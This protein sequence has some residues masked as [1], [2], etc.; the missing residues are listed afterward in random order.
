MTPLN[1]APDDARRLRQAAMDWFVRRRDAGWCAPDE[2]AFQA[3]LAADPR[4]AEVYAQCAERWE[5]LDGMPADLRARLHRPPGHRSGQAAPAAPARRRFLA[6][7]AASALAAAALGGV[8]YVAWQQLQAQPIYQQAFRTE[9]GQQQQVPLADGSRLRLDTATQLE[10]RFYRQRREVRL[11]DGQAVFEVQPDGRPF[12]VLAGSTRVTVVGTRFAV[13]YTPGL[14][15]HS[16]VQVAV[17]EGRVRVA[18]RDPVQEADGRYDL[19]AGTLLGAGQQVGADRQGVPGRVAAV[20]ADGIAP[21]RERRVSF[22]DV[23]LA[24]ALAEL[25]RY[26]PTGLVV[27]DPA[28]AAL[29]LS[30]SFDPMA[31]GALRQALPRVLPVRLRE[32]DGVTEVLAAD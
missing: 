19:Q 12:H 1:S 27:R 25:E 10:V 18:R 2:A 24:Q 15:G 28:V 26:R 14:P 13:R 31:A 16:G 3:W 22:V 21:W 9:R 4:H 11:L 7:P 32:Q 5:A 23:P 6:W 30:G 8:G 29:R 17:E 20:P